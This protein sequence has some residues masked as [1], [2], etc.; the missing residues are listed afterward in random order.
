M[1]WFKGLFCF[2]NLLIAECRLEQL[3]KRDGLRLCLMAA[4]HDMRNKNNKT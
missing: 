4:Y 1:W 2:F 3:P